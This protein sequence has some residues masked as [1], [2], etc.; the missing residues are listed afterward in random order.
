MVVVA[1]GQALLAFNLAALSISMGGM[2]ASFHTPPTSVGTAIVVHALVVSAFILLGAKLG[3]RFGSKRFFQLATALFLGAMV[4]M[5]ISPSVGVMLAAQA[6]A[7]FG[8]AALRP[9]LVVLIASHYHGRQQSE[10]FGW[11]GAARSSAGVLALLIIGVLE[12]FVSWRVAFG[13]LALIAGVTLALST[14]L[15]A[16]PRRRVNVDVVGVVLSA[17]GVLVFTL[18][19]NSLSTWGAWRA[20][21]AAPFDVLG[22]SPAPWMIGVGLVLG[23]SF[24]VWTRRRSDAGASPLL[25]LRIVR[26]SS[27]R[28]AILTMFVVGAVEAGTFFAVPLYIQ[29]VQG[30]DSFQ[31]A[32]ATMPFML[33]F[34]ASAILVVRM[35]PRFAPRRIATVAM[36]M[37]GAGAFWLAWVVRNDWSSIPIV[38]GLVATGLGQGALATLL[39]N[40]LV[41]ASPKELAGDVGALRAAINNLSS[42]VGT[43]LMGALL[44]GVLGAGVM[45]YVSASPIITDELRDQLDLTSV[46]FVSNDR[47]AERLA[48]TTATPEQVAEAVRINESSRLWALKMGFVALGVLSLL[49]TIPAQRLPAYGPG[50]VPQ[51]RGERAGAGQGR[52]AE[53]A[54][55]RGG[56]RRGTR[57]R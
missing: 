42:S 13:L 53:D 38:I 1:L 4:L 21:P 36:V 29:I 7:G 2:V 5:A 34:F 6:V 31:T 49:T 43:A 28:A 45:R 41:S 33:A 17:A 39:L 47:L 44:V 48:R 52:Y 55:R 51:E 30:R 32:V 19:L 57:G 3:E 35:F 40:V 27:E 22:T 8:G 10:A 20:R 18:G 54:E 9:T 46:N 12:R 25:D 11:L 56:T 24:I 37:V 23:A 50:E 15:G 26:A 14:M 16:S